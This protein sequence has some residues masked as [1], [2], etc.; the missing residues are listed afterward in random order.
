MYQPGD[1]VSRR[2]GVFMHR[3]IVLED[4]YVLHNTPLKGQHTSTLEEFS[5]NKSVYPAN[6]RPEVRD[7]TLSNVLDYEHRRYNPFNNN[8]EHTVTR[9]T[10]N[11]ARSPQLRGWI[12]GA[13][14]AAIGFAVTRH[15]AIAIAGFALGKKLGSKGELA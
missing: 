7:R 5:K 10:K 13:A 11:E 3:G 2:K 12:V 6:H 8:C 15:P 1:V 9:A 14:F 4:G